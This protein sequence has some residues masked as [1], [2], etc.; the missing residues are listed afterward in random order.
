M[1]DTT[2]QDGSPADNLFLRPLADGRYRLLEPLGVGGMAS[3]YKAWDERLRCH[4]AVKLLSPEMASNATIRKR[5][6]SEAQTMARLHHPNIVD[7]Q[8][9]GSDGE[10]LFIVMEYVPAGSLMDFLNANGPLPPR[11]AVEA[12]LPVLAALQEAHDHG[13]V[14]RDIK[15]HNVLVTMGG[16]PKVTDFGIARVT[17][18]DM[19]MTK[20]GSI[21][22]TWGFMAPEQRI[23]ARKVD[24]RADVYAAAS[25]LYCLLTNETPVDLFAGA[26]DGDMLAPLPEVLRPVVAKASRYK[27][28]ERYGS[29]AQLGAALQVVLP[30]LPPIPE[31]FP[32]LGFTT[33]QRQVALDGG[34]IIPRSELDSDG[35]QSMPTF[36]TAFL[37]L[38]EEELEEGM[39]AG[40]R[41]RVAFVVVGGL[42][43]LGVMGSMVWQGTR[44]VEAP[45]SEVAPVEEVVE[46]APADPGAIMAVITENIPRLK[47]CY[48]SAQKLNPDLAGKV[49]I[50]FE[51]KKGDV[52]R[53]EVVEDT[54]GN[55]DVAGCI[56]QMVRGIPFSENISAT[57]VYPFVFSPLEVV[58]V[59]KPKR[60]R[61]RVKEVAA[62]PVAEPDPVEPA[63]P[64]P[65]FTAIPIVK[66]QVEDLRFVSVFGNLTRR[67]GDLLEEGEWQVQYRF[68]AGG[69]WLTADSRLRIGEG[70]ADSVTCDAVSFKKCV[71]RR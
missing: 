25:T 71:V 8:D 27:P 6:E 63:R 60:S 69:G 44:R 7:V 13:V 11:L 62:P 38:E 28:E 67:R 23:S 21:M 35:P 15:P 70:L 18:E 4:R 48:E 57:V 34:T 47:M 9:V 16:R 2:S 14:H 42:V 12:M 50:E 40:T 56:Q 55:E 43:I 32:A 10:R 17:T 59:P 39:D 58:P 26:L 20:T 52:F 53:S 33:E 49:A 5:F 36:S 30:K 68:E 64:E 1:S 66:G 54:M 3:V 37:D 19:S 24:G 61:A 65:A 46:E 51:V 22:G 29:A 31:D 45:V 41:G